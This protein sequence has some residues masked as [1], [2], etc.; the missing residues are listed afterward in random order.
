MFFCFFFL[1]GNV[2]CI[3]WPLAGN[4]TKHGDAACD[5]VMETVTC[6]CEGT[7]ATA[8]WEKWVT[9]VREGPIGWRSR[10]PPLGS[11]Q[12]LLPAGSVWGSIRCW[13]VWRH[14]AGRRA[15]LAP[16]HLDLVQFNDNFRKSFLLQWSGAALLFQQNISGN[17]LDLLGVYSFQFKH[18]DWRYSSMFL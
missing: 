5:A 2:C 7:R 8:Q 12:F 1:T 10:W 9:Q 15:Q 16:Y 4:V 13:A 14:T 17:W 6:G 18:Q 11:C 3:H